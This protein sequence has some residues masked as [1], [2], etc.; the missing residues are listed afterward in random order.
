MALYLVIHEPKNDDATHPPTRM[1]DLARDHGVEGAQP[2]WIGAWSPDL[3]DDRLFTTWEATNAE[4][5]L[6]VVERYGFLN[7]Y[8]ASAIQVRAW[9]PQDVLG[10]TDTE[11]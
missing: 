2:Q 3:H 4:E 8:V 11:G 7:D 1:E 6:N 5:I 10:A 9:G